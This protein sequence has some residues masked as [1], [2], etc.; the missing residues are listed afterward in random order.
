MTV[1][2]DDAP[3]S[4]DTIS[5][6]PTWLT[7][8]GGGGVNQVVQSVGK[9]GGGAQHLAIARTTSSQV[10]TEAAIVNACQQYLRF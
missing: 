3:P 8:A 10:I 6:R 9:R 1:R 4:P 5:V 7:D 2:T